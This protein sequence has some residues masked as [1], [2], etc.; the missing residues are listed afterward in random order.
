[1]AVR[2]GGDRVQEIYGNAGATRNQHRV[3]ALRADLPHEALLLAR[4]SPSGRE[5]NRPGTRRIP[6]VAAPVSTAAVIAS[7]SSDVSSRDQRTRPER[8]APG[9]R[10]ALRGERAVD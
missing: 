1:M 6:A 7:A 9:P 8:S 5:A 3:R 10:V 2:L 4:Y